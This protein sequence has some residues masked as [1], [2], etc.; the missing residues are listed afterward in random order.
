MSS[1]GRIQ[2]RSVAVLVATLGL[3]A[4]SATRSV[5]PAP[6]VST[7]VPA[8][9]IPESAGREAPIKTETGLA[10]WYG[11]QHQGQLTANGEQFDMH[12]MTAAHRTWPFN[13][14]VR[15]TNIETGRTVKVRINDRGPAVRSRIIDVSAAAAAGLD[16]GD[17][18]VA[19]VRLEVFA[20]DQ[21]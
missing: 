1:D 2:R 20:S 15:V 8:Q 4:C 17:S 19:R 5:E 10:T 21:K 7:A 13:T 6:P 9:T 3:W 18:G 16:L 14:I 12:Q 11:E